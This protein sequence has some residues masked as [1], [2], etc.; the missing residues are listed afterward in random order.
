MSIAPVGAV[1]PV[2][3]TVPALAIR[4]ITAPS[5]VPMVAAPVVDPA[6]PAS[7]AITEAAAAA[8]LSDLS[9]PTARS[10]E[11]LRDT[12]AQAATPRDIAFQTQRYGGLPLV[13]VPLAFAAV[14]AQAL[15]GDV[16]PIAPVAAVARV[17]DRP[18]TLVLP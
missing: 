17:A 1:G 13:A 7:T 2:P 6:A 11:A 8:T 4:D 3:S 10:W 12:A 5:P 14:Q 16:A 15:R 9:G 18:R